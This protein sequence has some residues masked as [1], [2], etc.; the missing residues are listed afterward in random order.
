MVN[1]IIR[2]SLH[3]K[4]KEKIIKHRGCYINPPL[5]TNLDNDNNLKINDNK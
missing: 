5:Q 2:F 1:A 3:N 4:M